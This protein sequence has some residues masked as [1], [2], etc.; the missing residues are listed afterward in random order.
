MKK[1]FIISFLATAAIAAL[2]IVF[3]PLDEDLQDQEID[4]RP[5]E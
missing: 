1:Y 2:V 3:A 5:I 4:K